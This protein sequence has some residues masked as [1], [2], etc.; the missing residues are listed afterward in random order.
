MPLA[1]AAR[2]ALGFSRFGG[3]GEAYQKLWLARSGSEPAAEGSSV[4]F[5]E[6]RVAAH[7]GW[8]S[9]DAQSMQG[10]REFAHGLRRVS[11]AF[12]RDAMEKANAAVGMPG[13][14]D[15]RPY[16][17]GAAKI[18][19]GFREGQWMELPFLLIEARDS[20]NASA[21]AALADRFERAGKL[22]AEAAIHAAA[23]LGAAAEANMFEGV[24]L[25]LFAPHAIKA[26]D[27]IFIAQTNEAWSNY[28]AGLS[29]A[30]EAREIEES[31]SGAK[32]AMK[33]KKTL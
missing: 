14:D 16:T 21:E 30:W 11:E 22:V 17:I 9:F 20:S 3:Q 19:R 15:V 5:K 32:A 2:L 23:L 8:A 4:S 7:Y 31:L 10:V 24:E 29:S 26:S 12:E 18:E 28:A 27:P 13:F 33:I 6:S 1:S 25:E